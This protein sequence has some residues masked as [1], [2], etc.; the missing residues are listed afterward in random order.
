LT[1]GTVV[2]QPRLIHT[3]PGRAR[4]HLAEWPGYDQHQVEAQLRRINGVRSVQANSLTQ[5]V[6]IR[7]DPSAV[8][9][10]MLLSSVAGLEI[11]HRPPGP[12]PVAESRPA[13]SSR[14]SIERHDHARRAR[15]SVPGMDREPELAKRIVESLERHPGVRARANMLTNRVLVEY[16]EHKTDIEDILAD[17]TDMELP[18]I[19]GEDQP[20][21]PLDRQPLIQSTVSTVGA[22]LGLGLVVIRQIARPGQPLPGAAGAAQVAGIIG[23]VRGFPATRN[24]MRHLLGRHVADTLF[25]SATIVSL[26]LSQNPIGLAVSFGE[27]LRL[28][29]EVLARRAAWK[30][31]EARLEQGPPINPG[32]VIRLEAGERAPLPATVIEG[33]GSAIGLDGLPVPATPGNHVPSGARLAGGPFLV[34]LLSPAPFTPEPR[35]APITE[36]IYEHYLKGA[37]WLSLGYAAITA[38]VTRSPGRTLAALLVNPRTAIIGK[39]AAD[40]GAS[41]RVLRAGVTVTGTRQNRVIRRPDVLLFAGPR[42][43]TD[44][45]ELSSVLPLTGS[46]DTGEIL[47]WAGAVAAAAGSPWGGAFRAASGGSATDGS[48]DGTI[49]R[50]RIDGIEYTLGPVED[51]ENLAGIARLRRRGDA[52]LVLRDGARG[53]AIGIFALRPRLAQGITGLVEE[54]RRRNVKLGVLTGGNPLVA[55]G[56]ARRAGVP[57][58]AERDGVE[59]IRVGQQAGKVVA[60]L[61]DS[62]EAAPAFAACDLAIGLM[63]DRSRLPARA[64]LI[65]PDLEA[66]AAIV[67]AGARRN[68]AVQDAVVLSALS[69]VIGIGGDISA[70][71]GVVRGLQADNISVIGALGAGWVRLQG[72]ERPKSIL[73]RVANPTPERWGRRDVEDVLRALHTTEQGL[74]SAQAAERHRAREQTMHR[75][76]ILAVL[77]TQISSPLIGLLT[78][79]AGASLLFGAPVDA[80]VVTMTI[81]NNVVIGAWLERRTDQGAEALQR[82]STASARVLRDGHPVKVP[83]PDV[84]PGDILLLAPGDRVAADARLLSSR[85]LEVDEAA[86]TGESLPV[87]KSA[88]GAT[89]ASRVILEGSD[90]TVGTGQA[91]VVAVGE[92]TRMGATL[93]ATLAMNGKGQENPLDARLGQ[94]LRQVLPLAV[95]GGAIVTSAGLLRRQPPLAQFAL[96]SSMVVA[97]IPEGL[98][99]LAKF[100]ETA[101]A[102]R[103]ANRR[104]LIHRLSAVEALGRV[105]VACT[106]KTGTMTE[107]HLT[108]SAVADSSREANGLTDLPADLR[109]VLLTAALASPHPEAQDVASHPTDVAIIRGAEAAGLGEALRVERGAEAPFDPARPFHATIVK[110]RLCIK[111]A[112]EAIVSRCTRVHSGANVFILLND[113]GRQELMTRA[114]Q[115]AE[116]GLR[117]LMVAEGPADTPIDN[118]RELT[119]LGFLG[120]SDPLRPTVPAA[121]RRCHEAG[122]RVI[123]LTGDHP[124]TARAIAREAGLLNGDDGLLTG[125]EIVTLD[126]GEL[127]RRLEHTTVVA[128]T[129]PL[130]KLRIIESLQRHGS[131]VAMTG[132]GV[133]DAPALRLA[134]VGVAMGRSGTEVARQAADVVLADDDFSTLV[135]ALVEGRSFWRNIRRALGLL[136]GGNVGEIA[137][138]M[139]GS[140]LGVSAPLVARQVLAV[141]LITDVLPSVTVALQRPAHHNLAGLAREGASALQD[142]L[143]RDVVR[144]AI[145]TAP[146]ALAAYLLALPGGLPQA[147][148]V[149]FASIIAGQLAQTLELGRTEDGWSRPVLAAVAGSTGILIAT[150][151]LPPLQSFLSLTMLP[152]YGW[153]L[154]GAASL[155]AVL[156]SQAL[157]FGVIPSPRALPRPR[158]R[159]A[160]TSRV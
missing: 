35:P 145:S 31:L 139:G 148:S 158:P 60:F 87:P 149:A 79:A 41:A 131:T 3:I 156:L 107:G 154:V 110:D 127:D 67:E 143:R 100:G 125:A 146:P 45:A 8:D 27:G 39:E 57:L 46:Y 19:T 15:I 150:L 53:D 9:C 97:A 83:A 135:E 16:Q 147:R 111:G 6:L 137:L 69:N 13:P 81:I 82:M 85:G 155:A 94:L 17:I 72:S 117:V 153:L 118:P 102:N 21:Y 108:L 123:M 89:D 129:T 76:G 4:I 29:T 75:P 55:Q 93:A 113:R 84:V 124:A 61:A 22:A 74:T 24:G 130:D 142:P 112:P 106:D 96:G 138:M 66:V 40:T 120:I 50:A 128:R 92:Q 37:A 140:V 51:G 144:R 121:V 49:A 47:S 2:D 63:D 38:L 42:L 30:E 44:G 73:S 105:D 20:A 90:I 1:S 23:I 5:N 95:A 65:A 141:N 99:L 160:L 133:N 26:A 10:A 34:K 132:D 88:N 152:L 109:R 126:N 101:V 33:I 28:L 58:L 54:C 80:M 62:A 68:A 36:S 78:I 59:A 103:L 159:L 11:A 70:R 25:R 32:A 134:D 14:I 64:D 119:A 104:A 98:P 18:D 136:L 12:T 151:T 115:L 157:A 43:L 7:F 116:R 114:R 56:V 86:L 91:V 48:F 77:K 52:V 122:V 71:F